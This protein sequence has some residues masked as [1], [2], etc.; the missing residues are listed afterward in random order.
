MVVGRV[1]LLGFAESGFDGVDAVV[2]EAGDFY[3]GADFRGLGGKAL[4]DIGMELFFDDFVGEGDFVPD[5]WVSVRR[6][7]V[8]ST[9]ERYKGWGGVGFLTLSRA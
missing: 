1:L 7:K 3:V 9:V 6:S 8:S 2:A 5:F 4:A